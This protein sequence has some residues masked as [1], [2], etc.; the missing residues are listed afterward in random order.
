LADSYTLL[1]S[2]RHQQSPQ[3]GNTVLPPKSAWTLIDGL[4]A[5]AILTG[6][7]LNASLGLVVVRSSLGVVVVYA[8]APVTPLGDH[9]RG[10]T[11]TCKLLC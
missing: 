6:I 10:L 2:D 4:L 9:R 7:A 8:S 3:L 11:T 5:A 1:T